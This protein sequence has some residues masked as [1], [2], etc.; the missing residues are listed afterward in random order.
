MIFRDNGDK[1]PYLVFYWE[2]ENAKG[3]WEYGF[4]RRR[5]HCPRVYVNTF[6]GRRVEF[7][8]FWMTFVPKENSSSLRNPTHRELEKARNYYGN[9]I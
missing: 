7:F 5:T 8:G 4:L 6:P 3:F 1:F 9:R 2:F